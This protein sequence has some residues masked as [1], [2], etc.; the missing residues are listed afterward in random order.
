MKNVWV[1]FTNRPSLVHWDGGQLMPVSLTMSTKPTG[2]G[3]GRLQVQELQ[4]GSVWAGRCPQTPVAGHPP[5]R[6][7]GVKEETYRLHVAHQA[8]HLG[9]FSYSA[10]G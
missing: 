5:H 4:R 9:T 10:M 6:A 8:E 3:K 1:C 2:Y 7:A